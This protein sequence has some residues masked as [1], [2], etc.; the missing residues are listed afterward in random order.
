[1]K[2]DFYSEHRFLEAQNIL[3]DCRV[4]EDQILF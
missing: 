2:N 3:D 1:M 4:M